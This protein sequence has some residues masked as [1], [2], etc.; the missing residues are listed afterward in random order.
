[1]NRKFDLFRGDDMQGIK[2][3]RNLHIWLTEKASTYYWMLRMFDPNRIDSCLEFASFLPG[4]L[5]FFFHLFL[6]FCHKKIDILNSCF[7][8]CR[9]LSFAVYVLCLSL[10]YLTGR[11]ISMLSFIYIPSLIAIFW[12]TYLSFLCSATRFVLI[13]ATSRLLLG[14]YLFAMLYYML[15]MLVL[16]GLDAFL[17]KNHVNLCS[18]IVF[19]CYND[20]QSEGIK[21]PENFFK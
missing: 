12:P 14:S 2:T 3:I 6:A 17:L 15:I 9:F 5:C 11:L 21:K 13:V 18:K 8:P 4:V 7:V 20:W 16:F 19:K 10:C 1:M